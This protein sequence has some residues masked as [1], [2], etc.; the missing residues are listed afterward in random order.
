M[1][2][3]PF[4]G[5]RTGDF[6]WFLEPLSAL[7]VEA[8]SASHGSPPAPRGSPLEVSRLLHVLHMLSAGLGSRDSTPG[9]QCGLLLCRGIGRRGP[10]PST[11]HL[12]L[13]AVGRRSLRGWVALGT[14]ERSRFSR[15]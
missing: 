12:L 15:R 6:L 11:G 10:E 7:A 4:Q 13:P 2:P 9:V 8:S 1:C 5:I 14:R 3:L